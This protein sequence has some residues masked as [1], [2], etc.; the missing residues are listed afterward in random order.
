MNSFLETIGLGNSKSTAAPAANSATPMK[1]SS[2][3][4][5]HVATNGANSVAPMKNS[6]KNSTHV[7]TNGSNSASNSVAPVKK[8]VANANVKPAN[9]G[10]T[11]KA[12]SGNSLGSVSA[13][14]NRMY[15]GGGKRKKAK[16]TTRR[17]KR[18]GTRRN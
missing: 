6:G 2:K 14:Y 11:L 16:K 8:A 7:A 3:N 18:R 10:T 12:K 15:L 13:R 4:A 1:N 5:T 9:N 17:S